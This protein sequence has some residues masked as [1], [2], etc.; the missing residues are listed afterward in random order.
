MDKNPPKFATA[1]NFAI[2]SLPHYLSN[3]LTDVT[4]PLLSPIRLFVFVMLYYGG[5]HKSITGSY[6]FFN[7][8]VEKN[9]GTLGN[10]IK[11]FQ[12]N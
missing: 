7:Q 4:S 9:V 1:N 5:A 12:D 11:C 8:D 3:L 10:Q 6:S 2:G